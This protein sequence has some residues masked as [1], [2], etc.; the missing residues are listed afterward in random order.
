MA[1]EPRKVVQYR[2]RC[3]DCGE[4]FSY[5]SAVRAAMEAAGQSAPER[6]PEHRRTHAREARAMAMSHFELRP[7]A[8]S[9]GSIVV[10]SAGIGRVWHTDRTHEPQETTSDPSG[11]DVGITDETIQEFYDKF[12]QPGVQVAV[13]EGATGSGKSTML[14]YRLLCPPPGRRPDEFTRSGPIVLTEPTIQATQ[15]TAQTIAAKLHG[16][17]IGPGQEIGFRHGRDSQ[18]DS[19]NKLVVVTDGTLINWIKDGMLGSISTVIID[20]AH[21]RST[22]IDLCLGMLR[23]ELPRWP[24]LRLI[25]AS[26]T[27]DAD[28]FLDYFRDS[29]VFHYEFKG[30]TPRYEVRYWG[31]DLGHPGEKHP[32]ALDELKL[33]S[34]GS[35]PVLRAVN[36]KV[37]SI[38]LDPERS[39]DDSKHGDILVFLP[40]KRWIESACRELNDQLSK[41]DLAEGTSS[42]RLSGGVLVHPLH[43]DLSRDEQETALAPAAEGQTKVLFATTIAETSL[44]IENLSFVVD[45]GLVMHLRWDPATASS[46]PEIKIHSQAGCKQRWGRVGRDADG[47]VY[48]IYTKEQFESFQPYTE[49]NIERSRMDDLVLTARE[50]GITDLEGFP[51]ITQPIPGEIQRAERAL[52]TVGALDA[53]GDITEQGIEIRRLSKLGHGWARAVMLADELACVVEVATLACMV[54][55]K[56]GRWFLSDPNWDGGTSHHVQGLHRWLRAGCTDDLDLLLR[57]FQGWSTAEDREAWAGRAFANHA[58]LCQA[59]VDRTAVLDALSG[60]KKD[61]A[62]RPLDFSLLERVRLVLTVAMPD[63]AFG[64]AE[65]QDGAQVDDST[66]LDL[67]GGQPHRQGRASGKDAGT[68]PRLVQLRPPAAD[69]LLRCFLDSSSCLRQAESGPWLALAHRSAAAKP[70]VPGERCIMADLAVR[71]R[72]EW[73]AA[74]EVSALRLAVHYRDVMPSP[75][76]EDE[77]VRINDDAMLAFDVRYGDVWNA[78]ASATDPGFVE[79][80]QMLES[81][82]AWVATYRD[83]QGPTADNPPEGS[84]SLELTANLGVTSDGDEEPD[85][86]AEWLA[87]ED[88]AEET[89]GSDDSAISLNGGE[90]SS[91]VERRARRRPLRAYLPAEQPCGDAEMTV[92]VMGCDP[93]NAEAQ[94][95]VTRAEEFPVRSFANRFRIGDAVPLRPKRALRAGPEEI[96]WLFIE[97][98]SKLEVVLEAGELTVSATERDR[99]S[100]SSESLL[101]PDST[102]TPLLYQSPSPANGNRPR[103]SLV[104]AMHAGLAGQLRSVA[105][106]PAVVAGVELRRGGMRC[107]PVRLV[108]REGDADR[109]LSIPRLTAVVPTGITRTYTEGDPVWVVA[110]RAR[111]IEVPISGLSAQ[112]E[113][114]CAGLDTVSFDRGRLITRG[115]LSKEAWIHLRE[116]AESEQ[117]RRAIDRLYFESNRIALKVVDPRDYAAFG[118]L[119]G[120]GSEVAGVPASLTSERG[121][122]SFGS[123]V[124]ALLDWYDPDV[125][126][127]RVGEESLFVVKEV[128]TDWARSLHLVVE[129]KHSPEQHP[130][131]RY[132]EGQKVAVRTTGVGPSGGLSVYVAPGVEGEVPRSHLA[133]G[134]PADYLRQPVRDAIILRVDRDAKRLLLEFDEKTPVASANAQEPAAVIATQMPSSTDFLAGSGIVTEV[135]E[136]RALIKLDSGASGTIARKELTWCRPPKKAYLT[137]KKGARVEHAAVLE[138]HSSDGML[139][140]TL[141]TAAH[142]PRTL[143]RD[144]PVVRG[145]V[146]GTDAKYVFVALEGYN[147]AAIPLAGHPPDLFTPKSDVA[148]QVLDVAE[149]GDGRLRLTAQL[150]TDDGPSPRQEAAPARPSASDYLI[151]QEGLSGTV[152]RVED[153]EAAIRLEDGVEGT[154]EKDELTWC[155]PPKKAYHILKKGAV[156]ENLGVN[157]VDAVGNRLT[158]TLRTSGNDPRTLFEQGATVEGTVSGWTDNGAFVRLPGYNTA[159]ISSKRLGCAPGV[160]LGAVLS[161]NQRLTVRVTGVEARENRREVRAAVRL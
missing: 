17:G 27:I 84:D 28:V 15:R 156:V 8:G 45:T 93:R 106:V 124:R 60:H 110:R 138:G 18:L 98:N 150:L 148:V 53:D 88:W 121:V 59:D 116:S 46:Q 75:V 141:R 103:L 58:L 154:I 142:D 119:Y 72:T 153:E 117:T 19:R 120:A 68:Q 137:L 145:V 161:K 83:W 34:G 140:L 23:L 43:S 114:E 2:A 157:G 135:D 89:G 57:L 96:G 152:I 76:S 69:G 115:A 31:E 11:F 108:A 16:G 90:S 42:G 55:A 151:G 51:W 129:P 21:E 100:K 37:R 5:D 144:V 128:S 52:Q 73:L 101:G 97:P 24:H 38:L 122:V 64:L 80:T 102:V 3:K 35:N 104:P 131:F 56:S 62:V 29:G 149:G 30:K 158:L 107:L 63:R 71:T 109:L 126:P 118:R 9:S 159:Y 61:D 41:G 4:W 143:F 13:V 67:E 44:T 6:C 66:D 81:S 105:A 32:V 123:G 1:I 47:W 20:E 95:V 85:P 136:E 146:T 113:D 79:L 112:W 82:P 87:S 134:E 92:T 147:S 22:N 132:R 94:L 78:R 86:F 65:P 111:S 139:Q 155:R 14:P 127:L 50:A 49:P 125:T 54:N 48:T 133:T 33:D 99:Q 91:Q 74:D 77:R 7:R 39:K 40:T 70:T 12:L 25:I 36:K 26:A 10:K 160:A 130:I